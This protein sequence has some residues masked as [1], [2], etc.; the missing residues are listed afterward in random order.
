MPEAARA[1]GKASKRN[2]RVDWEPVISAI[3]QVESGGRSDAQTGDQCGAMQIRPILVKEC[4]NIL[5]AR[6]SKKRYTLADR[7]SVKKSIEMF[8][9]IQ[10]H[11]NPTN[12][13]EQA[14]RSWNGGPNYS[15][16]ATQSYFEKVME[17]L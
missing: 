14:I 6:N 12:N 9:L 5:K 4:N 11:H 1:A 3:I 2:S 15:R 16:R 13:L 17:C 8:L 7:F 10:S